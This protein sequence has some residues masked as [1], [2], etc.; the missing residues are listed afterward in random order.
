MKVTF[1]SFAKQLIQHNSSRICLTSFMWVLRS[2]CH[3]N[4][5]KLVQKLTK[6]IETQQ[7]H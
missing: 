4:K 3:V 5:N 6:N 7:E 2:E 1:L